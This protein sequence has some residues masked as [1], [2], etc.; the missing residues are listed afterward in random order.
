[1]WQ[2]KPLGLAVFQHG[3]EELVQRIRADFRVFGGLENKAGN[4]TVPQTA[5]LAQDIQCRRVPASLFRK[6]FANQ[7]SVSSGTTS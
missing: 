4:P 1:M 2:E 7:N 5:Q 6:I 3:F